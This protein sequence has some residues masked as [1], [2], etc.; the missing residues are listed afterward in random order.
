MKTLKGYTAEDY[1]KAANF[2]ADTGALI[3][4]NCPDSST[5]VDA[6]FW[7]VCAIA[8]HLATGEPLDIEDDGEPEPEKNGGENQ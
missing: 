4:E 5:H 6:L 8:N 3:D 1:R 7:A 2:L